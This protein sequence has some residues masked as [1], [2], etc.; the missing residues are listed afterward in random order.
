MNSTAAPNQARGRISPSPVKMPTY[1]QISRPATWTLLAVTLYSAFLVFLP[2]GF[3][4]IFG[5]FIPRLMASE[6]PWGFARALCFEAS[7]LLPALF[8]ARFY[9]VVAARAH[10]ARYA[11][12]GWIASASYHAAFSHLKSRSGIFYFDAGVG[13]F[14]NS[15]H[16]PQSLMSGAALC[17]SLYLLTRYPRPPALPIG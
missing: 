8:L 9:F 12:I 10:S 4:C 15:I 6:K 11:K 7:V 1:S 17:T 16:L 3:V 13:I 14:G 5:G 2:V